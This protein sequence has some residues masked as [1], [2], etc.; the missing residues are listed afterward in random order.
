MNYL[1]LAKQKRNSSKKVNYN[2]T[3][4]D[5]V[6]WCYINLTPAKYGFHLQQ[7]FCHILLNLKECDKKL[8]LG[9]YYFNGGAGEFKATYLSESKSYSL[10]HLRE[11]Q[12]YSYYMFCFID[13]DNDFTPEFYIIL[14]ED[15]NNLK[16]E[17]MNGRGSE[18]DN[19]EFREKRYSVRKNSKSHT[20]LKKVNLL[21]G[22][23]YEDL[24]SYINKCGT[25]FWDRYNVT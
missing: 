17:Y 12:P 15:L 2:M 16:L 3:I 8:G 13:S 22:T 6:C 10:L 1:K 19:N 9:D 14:K 23:T 18:N 11:W 20:Y 21:N 24:H 4:V 7:Y 5:F 25:K